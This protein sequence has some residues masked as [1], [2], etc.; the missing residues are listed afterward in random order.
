M[1][2]AHWPS[3][4][5]DS[6]EGGECDEIW[7]YVYKKEAHK[8]PDEALDDSMGDVDQRFQMSTDGVAPY[9]SATTTTLGDRCDFAQVVKVYREDPPAERRYSPAEVTHAEKVPVTGNPNPAKISTSH[10]TPAMEAGIASTVWT[11]EDLLS[12]A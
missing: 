7:A 2:T 9:K 12:R 3:D 5:H 6:G 8:L 10:I 4:G 11:M 1:R